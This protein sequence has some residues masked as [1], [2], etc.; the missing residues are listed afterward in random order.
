MARKTF[1]NIPA[2][3]K[4]GDGL[5]IGH[6]GRIIINPNVTLGNNVNL[7]TGITIGQANRGDKKGAPTI[8]N[9]VIIGCGAKILGNINIGD[10]VR[11]GANAVVLIDVKDNTTAVGIPA[12]IINKTKTPN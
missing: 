3:V 6:L 10:N 8:G 9:N 5:Y 2:T 11:I 12:K 4:A 1:I 7:S